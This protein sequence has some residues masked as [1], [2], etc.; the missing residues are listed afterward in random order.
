MPASDQNS[1]DKSDDE[2][3]R[4]VATLEQTG[5]LVDVA[6]GQDTAKLP[7]AVTHVRY[8]DGRIQR[9]RFTGFGASRS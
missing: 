1:S 5:Q 3:R 9:I 4:F 8:P 6:E 2:K 7:A